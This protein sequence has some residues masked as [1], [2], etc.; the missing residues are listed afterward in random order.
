MIREGSTCC[1][2]HINNN[3][4]STEA[5]T[6]IKNTNANTNKISSD[7]LMHSFQDIS[8]EFK[9][10]KSILDETSR[11]PS[12]TFDD[13]NRLTNQQYFML[14]GINKQ[15]YSNLCSCIPSASF[16]QTH[17]RSLE[18]AIG[19]LLVKLRIELSNSVF[20]VLFSLPDVRTV[21]RILE[22]ARL[23]FISYFHSQT[24]GI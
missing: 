22:S 13:S 17:L 11:Q 8:R 2:K 5:I 16:R 10:I 23:S 21:S 4:L 1:T 24:F 18:Q 9:R 12:I 20:A 3:C 14:T 15:S 19:C 7:E 6:A